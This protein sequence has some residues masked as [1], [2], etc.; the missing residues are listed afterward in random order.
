MTTYPFEAPLFVDAVTFTRAPNAQITIYDEADLA[1]T[2]P[3]VLTDPN[4]LPLANPLTASPDAFGPNFRAPTPRVK[5]SGG[6]LTGFL[7]SPTAVLDEAKAARVAADTAS[8]SAS[9][10]ATA[11]T[12]AQAAA[13]LAAL[14]ATGGGVAI[15]PTDADT[16]VFT[17]KSDGSIAVDPSDSDA[18]LITA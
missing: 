2:T 12:A 15:D 7:A 9:D 16:L 13:E 3:L 1:S 5:W 10:S 11:A 8:G 14:T 18:L 17:T 4:G 6:G